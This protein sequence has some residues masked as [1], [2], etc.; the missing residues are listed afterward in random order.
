[1]ESYEI[2]PLRFVLLFASPVAF[3]IQQ[4]PTENKFELRFGPKP[5]PSFL[6]IFPIFLVPIASKPR[7]LHPFREWLSTLFQSRI[8]GRK[9]FCLEM[10][11]FDL[12]S[13][14]TKAT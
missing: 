9:T 8:Q 1:M 3:E 7:N 6:H 4:V 11:R 2:L 5:F 14:L 13:I 12:T 10:S